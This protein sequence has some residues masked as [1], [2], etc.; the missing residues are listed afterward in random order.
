[1]ETRDLLVVE[2]DPDLN[3]IVG[4]Y[5]EMAGFRYRSALTGGAA[6]A[7]IGRSAPAA[8][9][10]DLMLP[11]MSG[12]DVCRHVKQAGATCHI[13]IIILSALDSPESRKRGADCGAEEYLAKPFDP[14]VFLKAISRHANGNGK[15]S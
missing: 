7:E 15:H 12:F 2:D 9:V 3:E 6:L 11:D 4:A 8:I 13:P 14:D 1:M 5:V 10:L